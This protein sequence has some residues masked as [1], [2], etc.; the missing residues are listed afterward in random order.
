MNIIELLDQQYL[1]KTVTNQVND[2]DFAAILHQIEV[3][4][5]T[6]PT[7][8]AN[9]LSQL[10]LAIT[11]Y[12]EELRFILNNNLFFNFFSKKEIPSNGFSTENLPVDE[13]KIK[14]FIRVFLSHELVLFLDQNMNQNNFEKLNQL[15]P[16]YPYFPKEITFQLQE[17]SYDKIEVAIQTLSNP[18]NDLSKIQYL[19]KTAFYDFLSH[20]SCAELDDKIA[21][22]LDKVL[23]VFRVNKKSEF[24]GTTLV[25]MFNYNTTNSDLLEKIK[26]NRNLVY[27]ERTRSGGS[28][29]KHSWKAAIII[30]LVLVRLVFLVIKLSSNHSRNTYDNQESIAVDTIIEEDSPQK[31]DPYYVNMQRKIDS[32]QVFLVDY[33]K[34]EI[35]YAKYNDTI[36]TGENPFENVYKNSSLPSNGSPVFF[37]NKTRYDIILFENP[38]AFDSIKMPGRA[39]FIKSGSTYKLDDVPLQLHRV[40]N[41]Y[42]GK[43]LASF[44]TH[45]RHVFVRNQSVMEPRFTELLPETKAI[46]KKD[47]HFDSN[48]TI[49]EKKGKISI[50]SD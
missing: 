25:S 8:N 47:Y 28:T 34:E 33:N 45:S 13:G 46:L 36:K 18:N 41:F 9:L 23:D 43:K 20:F 10:T 12:K 26:K 7:V 17:K 40:Y 48:V 5:I 44:V 14:S 2:I 42:I 31:L 29:S 4:K 37:K 16:I 38:L 1:S 24:A 15:I 11:E 35:Q 3:D 19:K 32:F 21:L 27:D 49:K 6:N 50:T 39:Y 30:V 22:L